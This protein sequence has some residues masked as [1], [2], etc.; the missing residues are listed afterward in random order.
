MEGYGN[1]VRIKTFFK[2]KGRID[3]D[4][5][6]ISSSEKNNILL[7]PPEIL[8]G[9]PLGKSLTTNTRIQYYF[10]KSISMIYDL[11]FIDNSRYNDFFHLKERFVVILRSSYLLFV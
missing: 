10:N 11:R 9:N 7:V 2:R 4:L 1:K 5:S 8:N 6:Y 3:I